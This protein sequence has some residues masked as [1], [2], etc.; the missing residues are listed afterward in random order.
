MLNLGSNGRYRQ[1]DVVSALEKQRA[2]RD[3]AR[4]KEYEHYYLYGR[5]L[6]GKIIYKECFSKIDIDGVQKPQR[7][8]RPSFTRRSK[9]KGLG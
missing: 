9:L 1:Y 4:L 6:D 2:Q 5:V 3:F 7:E 8:S